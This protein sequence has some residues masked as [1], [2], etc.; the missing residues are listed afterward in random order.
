M[1]WQNSLLLL[2]LFFSLGANSVIVVFLLLFLLWCLWEQIVELTNWQLIG[3]KDIHAN[4]NLAVITW[5][6][7][8]AW[9][10]HCVFSRSAH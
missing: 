7:Q 9:V 1:W 4:S 5:A 8:F 10:Y 6:R 3:R 2:V